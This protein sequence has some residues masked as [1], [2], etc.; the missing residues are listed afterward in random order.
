[1]SMQTAASG[2]GAIK[3]TGD[4]LATNEM[5]AMVDAANAYAKFDKKGRDYALQLI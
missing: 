2:A 3:A 5:S 4:V 1:M